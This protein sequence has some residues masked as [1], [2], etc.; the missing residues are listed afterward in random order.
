MKNNHEII[1][2]QY[3]AYCKEQP[4]YL[5]TAG[6]YGME[7]LTIIREG[8]WAEYDILAAFHPPVGAAV[9]V[10]VGA[11]NQI[12]VPIE[13]T[14]GEGMGEIVFAGYK[15]GV[16]QIAVDVLYKV[17]PS[18]G[19]SGTEPAEPTPDVVQQILSAANGA[20]KT[21]DGAREDMDKVLEA[22]S[23]RE[24]AE[25]D[26][27][28]AESERVTAETARAEAEA[29][30]AAA[31][32]ERQIAESAR[33]AAEND[34]Q[35]AETTRA[36][37][38]TARESAETDR[39]TAEVARVNAEEERADYEKLR[40][41]HETQRV[42]DETVRQTAES[43]RQEAETTR[44]DAESKRADAEQAR[45]EA[46]TD[47]VTSETA[48]K[49][50]ESKR[51]NAEQER[52][53]AEEGR[54]EAESSRVKAEAEREKQLP[55]LKSSVDELRARQNILVGTETGNPIS[56]DDAFAAPLCGLTVYGKSTQDGAP[57]PDAPVPI[58]SAGDG[59]SVVAKVTGKN[60]LNPSLFQNNKYQSFNAETGYYEIDSANDYWITGI[61]PCLP[62]TTYHF[63]VYIEGGC[64][65][66]EKK[67]VI[68][69]IGFEVTVKTP[70]KCAYYCINF[71]S[72]RVPYGSPVIATVSEPATYSPYREQLLTL[73]TPNGLPGIPVTSGGNYTDQNGQQWVC[74]EI[75]LK[76]GVKVQRIASFVIDAKNAN[77]IF[78]TNAFTYV[79]AATSA[80]L[81]TPQKTNRENRLDRCV[82][83]EVLSWRKNIWG[84]SVNGINFVENNSVDV[85]IENSYLG[86]SEAST[87]DER[88]TALVKYF[89]DNPCQ[90]VYR[91]ASPVETPLTSAEIAAYK[92]L[93]AYAPDT[94]VQASDGAGVK[95]AY[96]RD[97]NI[98]IKKLEDA[99]AS[100]TTT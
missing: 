54:V 34:R 7:M 55:A 38:E 99:I 20:V 18:S 75:D 42:T 26:R 50:A 46:E 4:L 41:D 40:K 13:A 8:V 100:M 1:L 92:A 71:S 79:T 10:R 52:Q 31:E 68:G 66:D 58:V 59:G 5:G 44:A 84:I 51:A 36:K 81:S 90:V 56:V 16:R 35:S 32:K 6:S 15:E 2:K 62:S 73:Q 37:A 94:V 60:L 97:V 14:A 30:R 27:A 98:T 96:Q 64:F 83:C 11:N 85:V 67:N 43:K 45:V 88:K 49:D 72:V 91:I 9:Q 12:D 76:K 3:A 28:E 39:A 25:A 21:A 77:D 69:I 86:L 80:R 57:T 95:L 17:A 89:T 22:E 65:Y 63:N 24:T 74:D 61:Q 19:A 53:T 33:L 48:R 70:S 29:Y 82:F 87:N 47:R 23:G 78:V 93:T